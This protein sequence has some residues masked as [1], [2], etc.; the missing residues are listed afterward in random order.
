MY[1]YILSSPMAAL[2]FDKATQYLTHGTDW[3]TEAC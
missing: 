3:K 1:T 2:A